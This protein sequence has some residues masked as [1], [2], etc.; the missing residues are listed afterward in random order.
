MLSFHPPGPAGP[1]SS[2]DRMIGLLANHGHWKTMTFIAALRLDRL[3]APCVPPRAGRPARGTPGLRR[4]HQRRLFSGPSAACWPRLFQRSD[5]RPPGLRSTEQAL[6]RI[7]HPGDVVVIDNLSSDKV[8]GVREAIEA[9][10]ATLLDLPA[11]RPDF[12]PIE[13]VFAKLTHS[14][15]KA[16]ARTVDNS[17][18]A[19]GKLLDSFSPGEFRN[20]IRNTGYC[21]A[22]AGSAL[23]GC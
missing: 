10:G 20:Y 23:A 4:P 13:Q 22:E 17:S 2:R 6:A 5:R 8:A 16:R 11:Y 14:R 19:I 9:R 12:N 7:L 3:D 18:A 1:V 15:R 21:S